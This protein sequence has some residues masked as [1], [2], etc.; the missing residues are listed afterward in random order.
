MSVIDTPVLVVGAGPVGLALAVDLGWR[1]IACTLI[2]QGSPE[3]RLTHPRMD[4]VGIRTME[5]AR[6]WGL[7][8]AIENAGFPRDLP[9]SIVYTT[10]VLGPELERDVR[11]DKRAR[12]R[13]AFSP[14]THEICPQ[15]FFDPVMQKAAASYAQNRLLYGRRL[16]ALDQTANSVE[17]QVERLDDGSTVTIRAQ[18]MVAADG[19][20]SSTAS[21]L[22]LSPQASKVLAYSTNIFIR[23]PALAERTAGQR[24]Y[25]YI[26]MAPDGVWASMVNIDGQDV[27]RLQVLGDAARPDWAEDEIHALLSRGLGG[28]LPYEVQSIVP[29]ARR[30]LVVGQYRHGRCFL[31]GDAA[32][33][34]SPTG[35]YGMNTG[36]AEAMNLSWKLAAVLA[37]W[38]GEA[39]L[40]S[41]DRERRPVAVRNARQASE[42][43]AAMRSGPPEARLLEAGADGDAI[44]AAAG[45]RLRAAM[46]REWNSF[47]IHLG[48]VY[49]DSPVIASE[50]R[51]GPEPDVARFVQSAEPG[52]RAPHVWLSPGQSIID[53][54][55]D[56]FVLLEF[57][58]AG[59]V[60]GLLAAASAQGVPLR[61]HTIANTEARTLYAR[62]FVL[63]RPDGYV[64]W[65][66]D[67]IPTDQEAL[68][69]RVRGA[70]LSAE[71]GPGK[72]GGVAAPQ[73]E[74]VT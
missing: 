3:D 70:G 18:Y 16:V 30:E 10:S 59:E 72:T 32:H 5:I 26:L 12:S 52:A 33:Q 45:A 20:G 55:G 11:P 42:N 1:G 24:A 44:R 63:V 23:C 51:E 40:D 53:L 71:I 58:E 17:A 56:G 14:S 57:G 62:R 43:F 68:I 61:H 38:G 67:A 73:L 41:Y 60:T 36:I 19:A 4:N 7:V 39:L 54:F 8:D 50:E 49:R 69:A 6:R 31:A 15:N 66:G 27:W 64:A 29:W 28:D 2:D 21:L 65:R 48:A 25:R 9:M 37:G 46:A 34:F 35:G 13:P 47:G 22:G 74:R